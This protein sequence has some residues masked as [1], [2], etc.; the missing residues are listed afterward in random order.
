[1]E[2]ITEDEMA[3]REGEIDRGEPGRVLTF[4]FVCFSFDAK[5]GHNHDDDHN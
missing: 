3:G 4:V 2:I 5:N 1:M